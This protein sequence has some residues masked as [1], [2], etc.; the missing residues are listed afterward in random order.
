MYNVHMYIATHY[1]KWTSL[2]E[3]IVFT[4]SLVSKRDGPQ[5]KVFDQSPEK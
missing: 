1:T 3:R 4:K 2:H 5:T